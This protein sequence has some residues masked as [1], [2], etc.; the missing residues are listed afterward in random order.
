MRLW[1]KRNNVNF[2]WQQERLIEFQFPVPKK[3]LELMSDSNG[4][5]KLDFS[6]M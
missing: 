2:V 6:R 1:E 3:K 4:E 5:M